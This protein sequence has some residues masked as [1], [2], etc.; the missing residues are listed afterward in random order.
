MAPLEYTL[1]T[2]LPAV[3]AAGTGITMVVAF[4]LV[5]VPAGVPLKVT[6]LDPCGVPKFVPVIVTE[7]PVIPDVGFK[8]LMFGPNPPVPPAARKATIC[9]IQRPDGLIGAVA[10]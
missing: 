6:V 8:L 7:V 1:T 3:A 5:A 9:M 10:L 2:T 4:Q